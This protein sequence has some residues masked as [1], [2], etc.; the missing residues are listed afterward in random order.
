MEKMLLTLT[1]VGVLAVPAGIALAQSGTPEP[2][3][4]VPTCVDPVHDRDRDRITDQDRLGAQDQLRTQL[5]T[6]LHLE[7]GT[8]DGD[9]TGDQV[10][11]QDQTRLQDQDPCRTSPNAGWVRRR[12]QRPASRTAPAPVPCTGWGWTMPHTADT[13]TCTSPSCRDA[14]S[15]Q[16]AVRRPSTGASSVKP[17]ADTSLSGHVLASTAALLLLVGAAACAEDTASGSRH[18][19]RCVTG[20]RELHTGGDGHRGRSRSRDHQGV[21][22]HR[23]RT[24]G[25]W[26]RSGGAPRTPCVFALG[27]MWGLRIFEHRG[28][29][30]Q[31]HRCGGLAA[32]P[33]WR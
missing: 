26:V 2:T 8:C 31:P 22:A 3:E 1:T 16:L 25:Y 5:R 10:R 17:F 4:P 28:E 20:R 30:D 7:D 11:M 14:T 18:D 12:D 29:R 19:V 9:C 15:R 33:V 24:R 23:R 13:H 27:E 21:R 32:R 6:Q